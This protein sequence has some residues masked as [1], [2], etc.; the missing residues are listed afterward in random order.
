MQRHFF[1]QRFGWRLLCELDFSAF[2]I[3]RFPSP[4]QI[5]LMETSNSLLLENF[6]KKV[7]SPFM[8]KSECDNFNLKF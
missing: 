5:K 2:F 6:L 8:E 4:N 7:S 1:N 3:V